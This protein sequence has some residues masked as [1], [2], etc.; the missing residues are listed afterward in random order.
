MFPFARSLARSVGVWVFIQLLLPVC[1]CVIMIDIYTSHQQPSLLFF[2]FI[3]PRAYVP[4]LPRLIPK[5]WVWLLA[6]GERD[7]LYNIF[8]IP[9]LLAAARLF[10]A[11]VCQLVTMSG[12]GC[13]THL[14]LLF[15]SKR[16]ERV[17]KKSLCFWP[18]EI[19]RS[20][21]NFFFAR[22]C[23]LKFSLSN[24][25]IE[26]RRFFLYFKLLRDA[27]YILVPILATNNTELPNYKTV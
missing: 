20:L 13:S 4:S 7:K 11:I 15:T 21:S 14:T 19:C 2:F 16:A 8:A 27:S 1:P 6:W 25:S 22:M 3:S 5:L 18:S 9:L 23:K 26:N 24:L 17:R 10:P 12:T